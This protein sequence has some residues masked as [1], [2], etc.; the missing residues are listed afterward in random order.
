MDGGRRD[1]SVDIESKIGL[2]GPGFQ[3]RQGEKL[4]SLLKVETGSATH[5]ASHLKGTIPVG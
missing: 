3:S 5:T 1:T 4:F 2:D